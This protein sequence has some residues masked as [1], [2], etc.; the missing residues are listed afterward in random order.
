MIRHFVV[1]KFRDT[2]DDATKAALYDDLRRLGDHLP[3][4]VG[5]HAG[6]NVS[7]ETE[8][9]RGNHDA[10]WVD[11]ADVAARDAYLADEKHRQ[12]GARIVSHT[13]GGADGVTVV[14]IEL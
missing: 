9:I 2:V 1:L 6:R 13:V 4:M 7:V 8:L 12:V 5:F 10:F 14:D 11:F 3:G